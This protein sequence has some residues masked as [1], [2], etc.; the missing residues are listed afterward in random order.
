MITTN[1]LEVFLR[2]QQGLDQPVSEALAAIV[3]EQVLSWTYENPARPEDC[4]AVIAFASGLR[5]DEY[6]NRHPGPVNQA[7]AAL[8][9]KH[10]GG[11]PIYAQW[12]IAL[13]L[14]GKI[15]APQLHTINPTVRREKGNIEYLSTRGVLDAAIAQ[16]LD[17]TCH[18][19]V[20][21]VAHRYHLVRCARL[22]QERGFSA[23]AAPDLP[24]WFDQESGQLWT[25][26]ELTCL[27]SEI[28]SR[29]A[30]YRATVLYERQA[31]QDAA[32]TAGQRQVH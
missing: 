15:P 27:V 3:M 16:G 1:A 31:T 28:I 14:K 17:P 21:V 13:A 6:G 12:E 8:V 5:F 2:D 22:L 7:L 19:P 11:R 9:E 32:D 18:T 25:A 10:S 29:L 30:H 23:V 26:G 24:D 4:K 20:L